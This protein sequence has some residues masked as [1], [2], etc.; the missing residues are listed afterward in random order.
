MRVILCSLIVLPLLNAAGAAQDKPAPPKGRPP[1]FGLASAAEKDG[2]VTI[3]VSELRHVARV[4]MDGFDV[5]IEKDHWLPLTTGV[6]GK[7]IRAYRPDGKPAGPKEVLSALARPRGVLY[8]LGFD[9]AKPVQPD[10]FYLGLLKEGGIVL[11]FDLPGRM[12]PAPP[13]AKP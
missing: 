9:K 7:D 6:L 4:K 2:K 11:A 12:L 13:P 5:F 10:P 3:E 8:F 1:Q